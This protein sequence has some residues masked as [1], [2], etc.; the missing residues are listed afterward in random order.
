MVPRRIFIALCLL[1]LAGGTAG[2]GVYFWQARQEYLHFAAEERSA[3]ARLAEVEARLAQEQAELERL[4]SDPAYVELKI[5][6][7]LG[8]AKPDE[9]I[10]KFENSE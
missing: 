7:R 1:F 3:R 5:R 10:F 2:A 8:Y 6:Q 9:L 4:R